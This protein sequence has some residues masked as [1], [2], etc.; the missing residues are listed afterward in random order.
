MLSRKSRTNE[1]HLS[2]QDVGTGAFKILIVI[3]LQGTKRQKNRIVIGSIVK[4][5]P[6]ESG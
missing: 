2:G 4:T 3:K 5:I 6:G 1:G